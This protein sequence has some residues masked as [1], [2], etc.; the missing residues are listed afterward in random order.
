MDFT[1]ANT[2][3]ISNSRNKDIEQLRTWIRECPS[4]GLVFF[5]GAGVSTESGIPDFRSADGL[6]AQKFTYPP[7]TMV[8]RSFFDTHPRDF[9]EFYCTRMIAPNA[10]PNTA[11]RKLAELEANGILSCIVTQN[12][13]G[14]HQEAGSK[15]VWELH[16]S[17]HRNFCMGCGKP[18]DLDAFLHL[19]AEAPDGIPRCES[20]GRI[21]KPDVVLYEEP[22]NEEIL[23]SALAA[24][25][26]ASLL[27]V[28][29][30][31]LAVNPAASLVRYFNGD[32]L[33]I[34][35]RTPT[36]Q[37]DNADLVIAAN[38]GDVLSF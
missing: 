21:V 16:G 22:L 8:S 28:A 38:I 23:E 25:A 31:S 12:I 2:A 20:C 17:V 7:E 18:Y 1:A 13:D 10:R 36:P 30:T 6:Y 37:D 15:Q 9:F 14:L 32:H 34:I 24:V 35:N 29:G 11:H 4:G 3:A 19:H 27:I 5:G 26:G 33:T